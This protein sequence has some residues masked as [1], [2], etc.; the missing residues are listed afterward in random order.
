[1]E[2]SE[3]QKRYMLLGG[4]ILALIAVAYFMSR[5]GKSA[6]PQLTPATVEKQTTETPP[7]VIGGIY[8]NQG[9]EGSGIDLYS[10]HAGVDTCNCPPSLCGCG[11]S[12]EV[13]SSQAQLVDEMNKTLKNFATD[14]F[15][16]V[17]SAVPPWVTAV[18]KN[19]SGGLEG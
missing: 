2:V 1:M 5:K 14:Y 6:S 18:V 8:Y 16:Q 3:K 15:N 12:N 17:L 13:L 9:G 10:S 4:G 7:E 11:N 19:P